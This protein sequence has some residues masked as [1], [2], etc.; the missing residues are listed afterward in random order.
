MSDIIWNSKKGYNQIF[1][2]GEHYYLK[3]TLYDNIEIKFNRD[4]YVL[5]KLKIK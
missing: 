3:H 1:D 2:D 5:E 4:N